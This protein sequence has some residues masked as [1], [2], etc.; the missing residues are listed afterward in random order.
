[1]IQSTNN[2]DFR[3]I[4]MG[5]MRHGK[6]TACEYL[7][8]KYGLSFAS[9]SRVACDLFIFE[10]MKVEYG[11]QTADECFE[12]RV[13]HRDYWYD[14]IC[15]FNTPDKG[16][17]GKIILKSNNGYCGIRDS[18][19]FYKLKA[20]G[21]FSVSI[22]VDAHDRLPPEGLSSM[23]L[24]QNDAE[25]ILDN[26]GTEAQFFKN[27]DALYIDLSARFNIKKSH[28]S[29]NILGGLCV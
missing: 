13:N 3:F 19:E 14:E 27:L 26:N 2:G 9:S 24:T 7:H 17:L 6:D 22:W 16:K 21:A 12:D 10:K 18:K 25:I 29:S 28:N 1:M 4:M 23:D 5:H 11:Y 8:K 15:E 20:D